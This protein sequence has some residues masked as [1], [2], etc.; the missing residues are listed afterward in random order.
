MNSRNHIKI[1]KSA[2]FEDKNAKDKKYCKV[3]D[4]CHYTREYR[5]PVIVYVI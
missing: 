5:G 3:G 1:Q 4:H 2:I